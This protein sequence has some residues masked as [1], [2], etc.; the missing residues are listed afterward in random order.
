MALRPFATTLRASAS[1]MPDAFGPTSGGPWP[2][3]PSAPWHSAQF[4]RKIVAPSA[5]AVVVVR[6]AADV[7]VVAA[8]SLPDEHAAAVAATN[9]ATGATQA[10]RFPQRIGCKVA[11]AVREP[12]V[13][14]GRAAMGGA[15]TG[16]RVAAVIGVVAFVAA[17]VVAGGVV[18]PEPASATPI[19]GSTVAVEAGFDHVCAITAS[20]GVVCWGSGDHGD[21]GNGSTALSNVPVAVTGLASGVL[22]VGSGADF[23][24]ALTHAGAVSCWGSG[25]NG[26]LGNGATSDS[27]VPVP[28]TGLQSGVTAIAVGNYS[29]CALT[30][31]GAVSCWGSGIYGQLGN[32]STADSSTPVGVSGL[33][34]GVTSISAGDAHVC[35]QLT[36]SAVPRCWGDNTSSQ[37]GDALL[38]KATTP[39]SV[40]AFGGP[41]R[42]VVAGGSNTCAITT[43]NVLRCLGDD[44]WGQLGLGVAGAD[45]TFAVQISVP[46]VASVSMG[47]DRACAVTTA[48]RAACWGTNSEGGLGADLTTDISVPV[49]VTGLGSG[50]A[51]VS[52]GSTNACALLDTGAMRCWGQAQF[53]ANGDGRGMGLAQTVPYTVTGLPASVNTVAAQGK[54]H[55]CAV[56]S[57]QDL[58]CWG[59]NFNLQTYEDTSS[60]HST[61]NWYS[62]PVK[63]S[64]RWFAKATGVVTGGDSTCGTHPNFSGVYCWGA[65]GSSQLGGPATTSV[66]PDNEP[67][68][69]PG[70]TLPV[71][72][73]SRSCWIM[74]SGSATCGGNNANGALGDG[75]T[76]SSTAYGGVLVSGSANTTAITL[77]TSHTCAR[78]AGAAKCWGLGTNGRLGNG[79]QTSSSV[80]VAVTGLTSIAAISAGGAH[81]CAVTSAGAVR[82]WGLNSSGQ[83]GNGGTT[84]ATTSV[85]VSGLTSGITAIGTG[86]DYSCALSVAGGVKCWGNNQYGQLGNG[87]TTSSTTPVQVTGLTSGVAYLSV[88]PT[89]A[90]VATNT[91]QAKCWGYDQYGPIGQGIRVP[92]EVVGGTAFYQAQ[93]L[94]V[95]AERTPAANAAGWS[96]VPVVVSYSCT[97][98]AAP[99]SCPAPETVGEGIGGSSSGT[100]TD[101]GGASASASISGIDVDLTAPTGSGAPTA[102]APSSGWYRDPVTVAWSCDDALSGVASCPAD[103]TLSGEGAAV[104]ASATVVDVAGNVAQITSDPVAI[105]RTPPVT[106]VSDV[107]GWAPSGLEVSFSPSDNL[108]G[109]ASTWVAVDGG[110]AQDGGGLV[111]IGGEGPHDIEVWSLDVA[112]NEEVHQHLHVEIDDG[113]PTLTV[114]MEATPGNDGWARSPATITWTC[115]DERSG[116]ASCTAPST[117]SEQGRSAVAG[118]AVDRA[119]NATNVTIVFSID[120][121]AP[122]AT[123]S[124][125]A[126]NA[127]GWYRTPVTV[128]WSCSDATSGVATCPG[129]RT[130]GDDGADQVAHGE[131]V[132]HAGNRASSDLAGISIDGTAPTITGAT[133]TPGDAGGWHHGPVTVHFSCDDATSGVAS[134]PEDQVVSTV[135]TTTVTGTVQDRAGNTAV[136]TVTVRIDGGAPVVTATLT[137][138]EAPTF[139]IYGGTV[140]AHLHATDDLGVASLTWSTTGA[141]VHAPTTVGG[142]DAVVEISATGTT[143]LMVTATDLS[144]ATSAP[145]ATTVRV[146][147]RPVASISP[148]ASALEPELGGQRGIY[149]QVTL[150]KPSPAPLVVRYHTR[151]GAATGC[152]NL[153]CDYGRSG[154]ATS[155]QSLTIPAG[156]TT[157]TIG[158][159]VNADGVADPDESFDVVIDSV[160]AGAVLGSGVGTGHI[161]DADGLAQGGKPVL[162]LTP[163]NSVVEG[164]VA[165]AKAQVLINLSQPLVAPITVSFSSS[166][167]D[168]IGAAACGA[169]ADYRT[170]APQTVTLPAGSMSKSIDVAI[171]ADTAAE[172]N[173]SFQ[174][175]H[176][177]VTVPAGLDLV[178]VPTPAIVEIVDDDVAP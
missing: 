39:V 101:A 94:A 7:V 48:G 41:L 174:V 162:L 161:V 89:H 153:A 107:P 66:S 11:F 35:A 144:G 20:G 68:W 160:G 159:M 60:L 50:V 13:G 26:R 63:V 132:D 14:L 176:L 51:A 62:A 53:G 19:V 151:D 130:L 106:A 10:H 81:S 87:T 54:N 93:P 18:A 136:G 85:Q 33:S 1:L 15:S 72:N 76:T 140:T 27:S 152:T 61:S 99:V 95:T 112:G 139:G 71:V 111:T 171:C 137:S 78:I 142:D 105:D 84:Q 177:P 25:L 3:V 58:M 6:L 109:V 154:S 5:D 175:T 52:V 149:F 114:A 96:N 70:S 138:A 116:V 117:V 127:S 103:S 141:E 97:G 82:C 157:G 145:H 8:P 36:S 74:S 169:G 172:G 120:S 12:G 115:S 22:Q 40:F 86:D 113:A 9:A 37:L 128:T 90:C 133:T 73:S 148:D 64:S 75:T 46:N 47:A 83:L 16:R 121:V 31:A 135:G 100:A 80:P 102:P 98:G 147:P 43:S 155:P 178:D 134:C 49:T 124:A 88:G 21:L 4:V 67:I 2:P 23:S 92:V 55:T 65:N 24:C 29:A 57:N 118:H 126:P 32:G 59:K 17:L 125:P 79:L 77:G 56:L 168:A 38:T 173:R 150:S 166:D 156:A 170:V 42:S 122:E 146:D 129:P 119:G 69:E 165:G 123:P 34:S 131:V 44:G 158:L 91:G 104:T 164:D 143:I 110:P 45:R 108:S 163:R 167:L 30:S 28:V